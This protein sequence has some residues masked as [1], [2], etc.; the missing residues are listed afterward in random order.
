MISFP[1]FE[2]SIH[3]KPILK[4]GKHSWDDNEVLEIHVLPDNHFK[5]FVKSDTDKDI[6]YMVE[7]AIEDGQVITHKCSCLGS[8]HA[9]EICKHRIAALYE[10]RD[11]DL[12][13]PK[14]KRK[15]SNAMDL[16]EETAA[17]SEIEEEPPRKGKTKKGRKPR[18][19]SKSEEAAESRINSM[20]RPRGFSVEIGNKTDQGK[21]SSGRGRK[22]VKA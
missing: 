18:Q 2:K 12:L 6:D 7:I 20:M 19:K 22:K 11:Q 1:D 17:G 13:N 3:K 4:K 21:V 9:K 8:V 10:I 5:A 15:D 14:K 16:E